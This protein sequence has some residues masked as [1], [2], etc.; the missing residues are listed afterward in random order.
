M[1]SGLVHFPAARLVHFL[2]AISMRELSPRKPSIY[3]ALDQSDFARVV[4]ARPRA[5]PCMPFLFVA[6][7]V[8]PPASFGRSV[9]LPPLPSAHGSIY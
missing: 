3:P 2:F 7:R 1:P 9:A 6:S 8:L 4:P 5:E